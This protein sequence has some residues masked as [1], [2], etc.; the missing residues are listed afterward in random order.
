MEFDLLTNWQ[1]VTTSY[2]VLILLI[3][4]QGGQDYLIIYKQMKPSMKANIVCHVVKS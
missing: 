4:C 1:M 3:S 2:S